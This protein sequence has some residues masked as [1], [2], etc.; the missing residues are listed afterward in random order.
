MT[1]RGFNTTEIEM[2]LLG[3]SDQQDRQNLNWEQGEW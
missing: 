2:D 1:E 3:M